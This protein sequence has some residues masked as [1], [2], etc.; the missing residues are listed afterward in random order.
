MA[1]RNSLCM[2][3]HPAAKVVQDLVHA[4]LDGSDICLDGSDICLD[5]SDICLDASAVASPKGSNRDLAATQ[6]PR[7]FVAKTFILLYSC[8]NSFQ[9]KRFTKQ[10]RF[11]RQSRT[12]HD[13]KF[14]L[15]YSQS[16]AL[17]CQLV[18]LLL[19]RAPR[20]NRP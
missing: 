2:L 11:P 17:N 12:S 18:W 1:N 6:F 10:P 13:S 14:E 3:T 8:W 15:W 5:G 7:N 20:W 4:Q 9:K 16:S 19:R